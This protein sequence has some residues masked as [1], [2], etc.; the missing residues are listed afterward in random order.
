MVSRPVTA[1]R[2]TIQ[3]HSRQLP[4]GRGVQWRGPSRACPHFSGWPS[5]SRISIPQRTLSPGSLPRS[6][7][8]TTPL[9]LIS[10]GVLGQVK[11]DVMPT[12][13]PALGWGPARSLP[14]HTPPSKEVSEFSIWLERQQVVTPPSPCH[15]TTLQLHTKLLSLL[16]SSMKPLLGVRQDLYGPNNLPSV[17]WTPGSLDAAPLG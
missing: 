1:G 11:S 3:P 16:A 12:A 13:S 4:P 15:N 17:V 10:Q 9:S 14:S 2:Q 8:S 7:P 6:C 5:G